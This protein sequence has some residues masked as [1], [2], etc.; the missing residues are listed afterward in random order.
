[1]R[2]S[3]ARAVEFFRRASSNVRQD[4]DV[5]ETFLEL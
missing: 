5:G 1:M 4:F 3:E 2:A